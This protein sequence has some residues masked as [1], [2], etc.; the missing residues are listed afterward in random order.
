MKNQFYLLVT[1]L[2]SQTVI[3]STNVPAVISSNQVWTTAGSPYLISDSTIILKG[4]KVTVEPGVVV[5]NKT[6]DPTIIIKGELLA[7]GTVDSLIEFSLNY[8]DFRETS[9]DYNKTTNRGCFFKYCSFTGGFINKGGNVAFIQCKFNSKVGAYRSFGF[10]P[11]KDSASILIDSSSIK[12]CRFNTS[13]VDANSKFI[14]VWNKGHYFKFAI[15]NTELSNTSWEIQG[16]IDFNNNL[17]MNSDSSHFF[18]RGK[19]QINCNNIINM[20]NGLH[21]H[22]ESQTQGSFSYNTLDSF[23]DYFH[24]EKQLAMLNIH[25]SSSLPNFKMEY[26]NFLELRSIRFP[27]DPKRK[28]AIQPDSA[29]GKKFTMDIKNCYWASTSSNEIDTFCFDKNDSS[30]LLS[31]IAFQPFLLKPNN[32]CSSTPKCRASFYFGIDTSVKNKQF[33]IENSTGVT[34][35][36]NYYWTFGDGSWSTNKTPTH[37]Y[38]KS[39]KYVLCLYIENPDSSCKSEFCDTVYATEG[40]FTIEIWNSKTLSLK[41]PSF[42]KISAYPNPNNGS[43]TV[44]LN[45]SVP[46]PLHIVMMDALGQIVYEKAFDT[47]YRKNEIQIHVKTLTNGLYWVIMQTEK[48]T[49]SQKVIVQH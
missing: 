19:G 6:K 9:V 32:N 33:I 2:F 49:Y 21:L 31:T 15:R 17:V 4:V 18:I 11:S 39:G 43:F 8:L 37:T 1:L 38:D 24:F 36:T 35:K 28:V 20:S 40:N 5:S 26:N 41:R 10:K 22:V 3:G 13:Y 30:T 47:P 27:G 25:T 23:N 45:Q 44:R 14:R 34:N 46:P 16:E 12:F 7:I 29:A 48:H 42:N